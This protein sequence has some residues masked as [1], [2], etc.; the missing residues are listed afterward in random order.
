MGDGK[1]AR[2]LNT[3][4]ISKGAMSRILTCYQ[5]QLEIRIETIKC[6]LFNS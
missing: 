3:Y 4:R 6:K 5:E 1:D 2:I